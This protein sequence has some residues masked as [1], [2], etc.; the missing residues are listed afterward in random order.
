MLPVIPA[1]LAGLRTSKAYRFEVNVHPVTIGDRTVNLLY[2]D[3]G[4]D[5]FGETSIA[6]LTALCDC[7][8]RAYERLITDQK[9]RGARALSAPPA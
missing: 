1:P 9:K 2:A 3:N 4:P 8:S 5:A 7:L 6:G